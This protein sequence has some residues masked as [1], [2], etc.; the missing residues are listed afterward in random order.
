MTRSI[1]IP[2]KHPHPHPDH[3]PEKMHDM[4]DSVVSSVLP[5]AKAVSRKGERYLCKSG[6]DT[7]VNPTDILVNPTDHQTRMLNDQ[8]TSSMLMKFQ[9]RQ[10]KFSR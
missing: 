7:C 8:N 9:R 5:Y 1:R 2:E 10:A 4:L 3:I 6:K